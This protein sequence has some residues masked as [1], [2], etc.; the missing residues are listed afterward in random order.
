M[1]NTIADIKKPSIP[2]I[3]GP[4][5]MKKILAKTNAVKPAILIFHRELS[6]LDIPVL[7]LSHTK[8]S[9]LKNYLF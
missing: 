1:N 7:P 9:Y 4:V 3:L 8:S 5:I 2:G 6:S